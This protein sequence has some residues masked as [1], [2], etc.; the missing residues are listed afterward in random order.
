LFVTDTVAPARHTAHLAD[1]SL[2][3]VGVPVI[4]KD[5]PAVLQSD[6]SPNAAS[7]FKHI[8]TWAGAAAQAAAAAAE[9]FSAAASKAALFCNSS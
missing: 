6:T 8:P 7:Q 9:A 2:L 1:R 4:Y 3:L 5:H